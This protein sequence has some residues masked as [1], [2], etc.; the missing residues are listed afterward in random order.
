MKT[1]TMQMLV[2]AL[3][4]VIMAAFIFFVESGTV[5]TIVSAGFVL[6]IG[7]FLG[8]DLANMIK[9]TSLLPAGEYQDVDI[10]RYILSMAFLAFLCIEAI[11]VSRIYERSFDGIYAS[12]GVGL[13]IVIGLFVGGIEA[14]KNVTGTAAAE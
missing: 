7:A 4:T 14:N 11:I 6:I 3:A 9:E 12:I 1:K 5:L 13:M 8:V 2:V 10:F